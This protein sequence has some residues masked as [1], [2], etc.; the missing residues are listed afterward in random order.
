MLIIYNTSVIVFV[1][2]LTDSYLII[3]DW[4]LL[5]LLLFWNAIQLLFFWRLN[6]MLKACFSKEKKILHVYFGSLSVSSDSSS[7]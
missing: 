3:K 4:F 2:D 5:N 7:P 1:H 6:R